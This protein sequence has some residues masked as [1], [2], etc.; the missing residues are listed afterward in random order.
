MA[1]LAD[2]LDSKSSVHC[3]HV[4]SIPTT[5]ISNL[6]LFLVHLRH[7]LIMFRVFF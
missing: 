5:G 4:G 1:E 3:G 7:K 2:A 6:K